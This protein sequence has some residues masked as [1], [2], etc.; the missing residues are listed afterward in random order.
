MFYINYKC[1]KCKH[2]WSEFYD[3]ACDAECPSCD[4]K[5]NTAIEFSE[6]ENEH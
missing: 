6:V 3:T 2:E 4:A 1:Y 5:A